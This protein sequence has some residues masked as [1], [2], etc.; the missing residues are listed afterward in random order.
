MGTFTEH[1]KKE[2]MSLFSVKTNVF[3]AKINKYSRSKKVNK[4]VIFVKLQQLP[5]FPARLYLP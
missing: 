3:R 2:R 1:R 5:V 4:A